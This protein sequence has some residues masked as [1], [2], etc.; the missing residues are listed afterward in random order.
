MR[1]LVGIDDKRGEA[2]LAIVLMV[3]GDDADDDD[4]DGDDDDDDGDDGD[5]D[6]YD[7]IDKR[8]NCDV[9]MLNG[10]EGLKC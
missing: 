7:D 6:A 2:M 5:G 4:D 10:C 8:D 1:I 9:V 3:A